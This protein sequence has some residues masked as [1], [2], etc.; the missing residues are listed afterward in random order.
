METWKQK[1]PQYLSLHG[2]NSLRGGKKTYNSNVL[3]DNWR[4]DRLD[5]KT[6]QKLTSWRIPHPL[7]PDVPQ[8]SKYETNYRQSYDYEDWAR[9]PVSL[10]KYGILGQDDSGPES[11]T[12]ETRSEYES[13]RRRRDR[14]MAQGR[15]PYGKDIYAR[16][17][18]GKEGVLSHPMAIHVSP[19]HR[20]D[21]IRSLSPRPPHEKPP[22]GVPSGSGQLPRGSP[23]ADSA[24]S[25]DG[26]TEQKNFCRVTCGDPSG[27]PGVQDVSVDNHALPAGSHGFPGYPVH[28][29]QANG[30]EYQQGYPGALATEG[31]LVRHGEQTAGA[32]G[33]CCRQ[34]P[35]DGGEVKRAH[36]I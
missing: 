33:R 35:E 19:T 30:G 2:S 1:V 36:G 20:E 9:R 28:V 17:V 18:H 5:V 7:Y 25:Q 29:R 22:A 24:Q 21:Y 6:E 4:N 31:S 12:T 14:L 23:Y 32:A 8:G 10:S 34:T 26:H 3:V 11:W 16:P 13:P 27:Q 15:W